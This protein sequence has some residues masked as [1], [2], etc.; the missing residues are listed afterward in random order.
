MLKKL[1]ALLLCGVLTLSLCATAFA[2]T[3]HMSNFKKST[4]PAPAFQ[5]VSNGAWYAKSV[6]TCTSYNLMKGVS[7]KKFNPT[8]TLTVAEA[9]TLSVRVHS[10]YET[11]TAPAPAKKG[12]WYQPYVT[13]ALKNGLIKEGDFTNFDRPVTRAETAYLFAGALPPAELHAINSIKSLS[14]VPKGKFYYPT[15]LLY[16]AGVL[17][18][19]GP[20]ARFRPDATLLRAEAAAI[21]SRMAVPALRVRFS[22]LPRQELYDIVPELAVYL[23]GER[24]AMEDTTSARINAENGMYRCEVTVEAA[25]LNS[26]AA[27]E[28]ALTRQG[29]TLLSDPVKETKKRFG[30]I[31]VTQFEFRANDENGKKRLGFAEIWTENSSTYALLYL[32]LRD[33]Q[34]FRQ[35][36]AAPTLHGAALTNL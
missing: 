21:V 11:G 7:E 5:D 25:G 32:T 12:R 33:S 22:L 19:T 10:I 35:A 27:L 18:G 4:A 17:T 28:A 2:A 31:P 20:D 29:Y 13:Y 3:P 14:D 1:T 6:R 34:E 24:A 36:I 8:G 30:Q 16:N 9:L 23:P 26:R 15:L